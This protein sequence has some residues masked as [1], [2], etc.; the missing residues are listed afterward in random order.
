V[1]DDRSNPIARRDEIL[2]LLYWLEGESITGTTA[3]QSMARFLDQPMD[4]LLE[5]LRSLEQR[6]DIAAT[7]L[8]EYKLTPT[9]REEAA[10]R[11]ADEFAGM[12]NQGHG[13]CNDPS[14]DC[15]SSPTGAAECHAHR[16]GHT[17]K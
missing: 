17:H 8:G 15:H 16:G 9:G 14:C 4:D 1:P 11:F 5:T 13:E 2:E 6:G 3:P 12:L 7:P 10:R